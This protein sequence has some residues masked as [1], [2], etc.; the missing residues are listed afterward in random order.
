MGFW[1]YPRV[2]K[3][4]LSI[5]SFPAG[6]QVFV[7][8]QPVG[9][10]P[11]ADLRVRRDARALRLERKGYQTLVHAITSDDHV[12]WLNLMPEAF[13]LN[14][15]SDPEGAEVLLDGVLM[16]VTPLEGLE[17][18]GGG[19][20]RLMVRKSGCETWSASISRDH[21]PPQLIR[22]KKIEEKKPFWKRLFGR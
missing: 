11:I 8:D 1:A 12:L 10:T 3:R 4:H 9:T 21:R 5:Q 19:S 7:D 13:R 18:S 22:L 2:F 6:A 16:G 20:H 15:K 17:V 14:L